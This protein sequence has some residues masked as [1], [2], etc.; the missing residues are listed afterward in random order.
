MIRITFVVLAI[1]LFIQGTLSCRGA[2]NPNPIIESQF[3]KV[4]S[5]QF[6][7]KYHYYSPEANQNYYLLRLW[8]SSY[9]AG[10]AYGT[11]LKN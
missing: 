4:E 3:T 7:E 10:V 5:H 11:L 6:G 8:G 2:P 9:Q 1:T